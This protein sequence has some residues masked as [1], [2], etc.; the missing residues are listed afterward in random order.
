MR[1]CDVMLSPPTATRR[2]DNPLTGPPATGEPAWLHIVAVYL[3]QLPAGSQLALASQQEAGGAR[4]GIRLVSGANKCQRADSKPAPPGGYSKQIRLQSIHSLA[5]SAHNELANCR[6]TQTAKE[7]KSRID[8][9]KPLES[10][11]GRPLICSRG[12]GQLD[13][14]WR[15][16]DGRPEEPF[17]LA[18]NG[19]Q[20]VWK[21]SCRRQRAPRRA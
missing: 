11:R 9:A 10:D 16:T 15:R 3:A 1:I 6:P 21:W 14:T 4:W 13:F 8:S 12:A 2:A 5:P 18:L 17:W 20:A 7:P 19:Q